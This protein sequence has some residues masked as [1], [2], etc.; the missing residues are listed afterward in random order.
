MKTWDEISALVNYDES[1]VPPYALPDALLKA[2]GARVQSAFEWMNSQ[3]PKI[4]EL[5]RREL[6]GETLPRPDAMRFE[7]LSEK[8][9][10][11]NGMALRREIRCAFEMASGKKMQTD[12]LLYIPR[13]ARGRVPVFAGL[14]FK[15]NHTVTNEK[16]VLF[17]GA[18]ENRD[19][20][21]RGISSQ[22]MCFEET[23]ARGYASATACYEDV[24][25]DPY[26]F[27]PNPWDKG[28]FGLL[29]DESERPG[30][31]ARVSMIGAWAWGLSRIA[32]YLETDPNIDAG[33][34]AVHGHS[35]L[36]KTALWAG[37]T[38]PRFG[39]V[40]SNDSGCGGAALYRRRFGETPLAMAYNFPNWFVAAH[41]KYVENENAM[42]F[43]QHMLIALMAPRP[44]CVASAT[45][46]L[47]ADPRGEY[48]SAYH[49]GSVYRLFGADALPPETMPP[50]DTPFSGAV[51]YHLRTGKHDQNQ[52][53]WAH[54][55]AIADTAFKQ[56]ILRC[57]K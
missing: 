57:A 37:A 51:S 29:F 33:R 47:W 28:V 52:Q 50:P 18:P 55:L 30:L 17:S 13:N 40:I 24:C 4:L 36:G 43:D 25:P 46:D 1:K 11:L 2:D 7:L 32:D 19:D 31:H 22:R 49:A 38:D 21:K 14:N 42:P 6:Y 35:R 48:L 26:P 44:V 54:Y 41:E 34:I 15:G 23:L 8:K 39:L 56:G 12:I 20:A 53:D 45:E 10:A 16:D 3:R 27:D 5:Y 9:D